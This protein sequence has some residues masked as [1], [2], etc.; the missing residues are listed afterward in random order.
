M[1]HSQICFNV[2]ISV[3]IYVNEKLKNVKNILSY[4]VWNFQT[5]ARNKLIA[6]C[7]LNIVPLYKASNQI[8]LANLYDSLQFY[9][10][11]LREENLV[12]QNNPFIITYSNDINYQYNT[13]STKDVIIF[14][15]KVD[16]SKYHFSSTI[17]DTKSFHQP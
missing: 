13:Q 1:F 14:H 16:I 3:A 4:L 5:S 17:T 11:F 6:K 2:Y 8:R 15:C 9:V 12:Y 7:L 10:C